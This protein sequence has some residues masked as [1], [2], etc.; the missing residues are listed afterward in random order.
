MTSQIAVLA[1][2]CMRGGRR[3]P[4]GFPDCLVVC[5]WFPDLPCCV[6]MHGPRMGSSRG[7]RLRM[8]VQVQDC[9][10]SS[11]L[12][13]TAV[14]IPGAWHAKATATATLTAPATSSAISAHPPIR[15]SRVVKLRDTTGPRATGTTA[16]ILVSTRSAALAVPSPH[17]VDGVRRA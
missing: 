11:T 7:C 8:Y 13:A 9:C 5:A 1:L 12:T 3:F 2:Q 16:T 10:R 4:G 14:A 17:S 15:R 6:C